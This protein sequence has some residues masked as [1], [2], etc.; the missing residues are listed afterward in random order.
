[1]MNLLSPSLLS[2]SESIVS[3]IIIAF[4]FFLIREKFFNYPDI[5]GCWFVKIKTKESAYKP[6]IGM[7]LHYV[8]FI[9]RE[10]GV[11][12]G[13]SEKIFENSVNG[14]ITYSGKNRTRAVL[15]GVLDKKYFSKD[16]LR[17]HVVENGGRESSS[18]YDLIF[19]GGKLFG[20]FNSMVANQSGTIIAKREKL[21]I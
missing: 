13:T 19:K 2:I 17:L 20:E 15:R 11:V 18:Y 8:I 4:L 7:E 16:R 14:K 6:F 3:A 10:G 21:C 5:D 12:R 9:W 1:M